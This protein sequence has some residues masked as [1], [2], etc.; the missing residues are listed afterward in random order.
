M[1]FSDCRTFVLACFHI[2][3]NNNFKEVKELLEE[4]QLTLGFKTLAIYIYYYFRNNFALPYINYAS[5]EGF[6]LAQL[7]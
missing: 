6:L 3:C 2:K 7:I 4:Q 1:L 5:K